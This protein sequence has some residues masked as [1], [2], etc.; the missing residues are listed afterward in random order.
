[1]FSMLMRS[2]A[3]AVF[4]IVLIP[5]CE[6]SSEPAVTDPEPTTMSQAQLSQLPTATRQT[7]EYNALYLALREMHEDSL[8]RVSVVDIPAPLLEYYTNALA[9]VALAASIAASDSVREIRTM[10]RPEAH[11]LILYVED[12]A[13][14]MPAWK[15]G[16]LSTG[17]APLDSLITRYDLTLDRVRQTSWGYASVELLA[18]QGKNITALAPRFK[19]LEHIRDAWPNGIGGDGADVTAA[20][21]SA[22]VTLRYHIGW[23]D[24]PS[25]CIYEHAW[26]FRVANSGTVTLLE[27]TGPNLPQ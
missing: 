23:G 26:I 10:P 7:I 18:T 12:A 1:M 3:L 9:H 22:G 25:G 14:W 19:G 15:Q 24:C 20:R 17:S 4:F 16:I 6:Q 21:D 2:A 8:T 5:A 11:S 13:P 27:I